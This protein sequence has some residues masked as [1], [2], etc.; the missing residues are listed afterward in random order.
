VATAGPDARCAL[1]RPVAP[2]ETSARRIAE[3]VIRNVPAS[4][5]ARSAA[6]AGR[7]YVLAIERDRD[8][9][10][11]WIAVQSPRHV[12]RPPKPGEIEVQS[13][14]G[15]LDF[16]IDRCSGAISRLYYQR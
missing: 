9:A 6:A 12:R 15:G 7:P 1:I 14:G 5:S 2:D 10:K 8:D 3:A 13:G 11:D 4:A 16:R